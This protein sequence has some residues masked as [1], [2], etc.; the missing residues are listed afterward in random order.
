MV[1][2]T[3]LRKS[4]LYNIIVSVD[5]LENSSGIFAV[6]GNIMLVQKRADINF[7]YGQYLRIAGPFNKPPLPANPGEFNYIRY[8]NLKGIS[9]LRYID[10]IR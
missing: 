10:I 7:I 5:S 8:L 6:S 9:W 4:G 3:Q 1:R 2:E